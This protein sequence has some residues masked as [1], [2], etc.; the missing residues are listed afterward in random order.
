MKKTFLSLLAA[1]LLVLSMSSCEKQLDQAPISSGSVPTFYKTADD[2]T[3]AINSV[4]SGLRDYPDRQYTMSE[5][6]SDNI[7][8]VS[9][10]GLRT[11]EPINNFSKGIVSNEYPADT[12]ATD[13]NGIFRAN[14]VLA[15]LAENGSVLTDAA[16]TRIEGEAKFLRALYY[17]DL[18]RYFGR[19]PVIDKPLEPQEVV[20]IQRAPV[21]DVYTLIISDLTT[22]G[23]NLPASYTGSDVGRATKWAAKGLLALTYLTRSGPVYGAVEGPGLGTNDFVAA[24]TLLKDVT[25]NS[26][27]QLLTTVP[28]GSTA[29]ANIFSY[30]NENNKEVLFDVQYISGGLGLG[31]SFPSILLT[32]NYFQSIGAGTGFGTGDELRPVSDNL[33]ASFAATDQRKAQAIQVGYTTTTAPIA[34]ETRPVIK[35]YVNGALKGTSRTDWPINFIVLRYTDILLMKAEAIL[36]GGGGT[37]QEA[38]KIVNDVR[39]RAGL[40]GTLTNVTYAQLFEERRREFVG[41]GLR[42]HDLIRSGLAL[43]IMNSWIQTEDQTKSKRMRFPLTAE[44]LLYPVPQA[45]MAAS[46]YLYQQNPGY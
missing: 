3:Q 24:Y 27:L 12:W 44:D 33:L 5:T 40:T 7:Y 30:T 20:K 39:A 41:E 19:V 2:F 23:T 8:G 22:A 9:T 10:Q 15:Q 1:S 36:K 34:V 13:F 29:Y 31:G 25:D 4:Y 16:R 17:L 42:W 35:K 45:E 18:V 11:W 37:Q 38:D 46:G 32:N 43:T 6:R 14:V 26:G 28:T 21:A